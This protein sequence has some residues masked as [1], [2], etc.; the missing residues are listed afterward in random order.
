MFLTDGNFRIDYVLVWCVKREE[1]DNDE[2]VRSNFR[3]V[4]EQNLKDEGLQLE[5]D[6]QVFIV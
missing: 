6:I 2:E 3:S 1:H 5:H 4:F